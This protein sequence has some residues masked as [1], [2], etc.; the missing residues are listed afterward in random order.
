MAKVSQDVIEVL[1]R[2]ETEGN[3]LRL[4]GQIERK[5]YERAAKAVADAGGKWNTKAKAMLFDGD[6][7]EAIEPILLTGEITSRK[8]ELQAFFTPPT[9]AETVALAAEIKPGHMVLEPSAGHGAL[10]NAALWHGGHVTCY[11]IDAKH[12]AILSA[13]GFETYQVD[14]MTTNPDPVFDRVVMNPPFTRQQDVKHVMHALKFLKPGGRLVAIMSPSWLTRGDNLSANF[15]KLLDCLS[16]DTI[17]LPEGS[18]KS[19]GT[20]VSTVLVTISALEAS[21]S[22]ASQKGG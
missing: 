11:D 17:A 4:T 10:A 20:N 13:A 9:L 18:F 22:V 19:S 21:V 3:A 15:R 16:A 6:A 7:A 14:F 1:E 5:L 12:V 2:A 8:V